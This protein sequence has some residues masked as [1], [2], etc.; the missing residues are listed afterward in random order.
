[1]GDVGAGRQCFKQRLGQ[2]TRIAARGL[3]QQHRDIGCEV[4][5]FAGLGSFDHEIRR[6]GV[7]RQ[8]AVGAQGFDALADEGAE[9]GFHVTILLEARN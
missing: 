8:S 4:A 1:M 2:C 3:G 7:G 6:Q 5:V 9:L